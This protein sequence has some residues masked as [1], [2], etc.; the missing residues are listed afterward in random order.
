MDSQSDP[1]TI[2]GGGITGLIAAIACAER[3]RRVVLHEA[4]A[5]LGGR[6]RSTGAPYIANRGPHALYG[7]GPMYRWLRERK[8]LPPLV[9]PVASAFRVRLDGRLARF[10]WPL[11]SATLRLRG[12]APAELDYRTWASQRA[13]ARAVE[14]AV[15]FVSLPTFHHDPGELSAAFCQER[16]R[17]I[18][19]HGSKVRYVVGGW[20]VLVDLLARRASDLGVEIQFGSRVTALEE[21]PAI[22]A[23]PLS[24]AGALLADTSLTTSGARTALLDVAISSRGRSP[25]VVFDLSERVYVSRVSRPD[26]TLAP[27]GQDLIQASAGIRPGETIDQARERIEAV[28]DAGFP[29]WRQAETWR[30]FNLAEHASGALDGPGSTW[31]DRPAIDQGDGIYLAGDAVAAPGLLSEV[32]FASAT[33]AT[34]LILEAQSRPK[35][36]A[37]AI[38]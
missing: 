2:I 31:R 8:L 19:L 23:L 24:A 14:A 32:G 3:G 25:G 22:L 30:R 28:I 38:P 5:K 12:E 16:F 7:D 6:A 11:L 18:M 37:S 29:G 20:S 27:S 26:P 35:A 15:G 1:I 34:D 4:T 36:I 9:R 13:G 10:P 33:R 17:R 21:R